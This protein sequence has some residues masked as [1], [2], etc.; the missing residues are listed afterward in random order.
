MNVNGVQWFILLLCVCGGGE[1]LPLNIAVN[2]S[3]WV[4]IIETHNQVK[5]KGN[6]NETFYF[7]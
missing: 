3:F 1:G 6:V 5:V 4:D 7:W 2:L